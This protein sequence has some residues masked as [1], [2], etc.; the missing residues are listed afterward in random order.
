MVVTQKTAVHSCYYGIPFAAGS[1]FVG[2][3]LFML[4]YNLAAATGVLCIYGLLVAGGSYIGYRW[5]NKQ[6]SA[7]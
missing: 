6:K 1:A 5:H 4:P 2:L 3:Y 7:K